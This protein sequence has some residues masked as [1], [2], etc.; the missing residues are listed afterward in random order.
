MTAINLAARNP[1]QTWSS[2]ALLGA[3][4]GALGGAVCMGFGLA[5]VVTG[6]LFGAVYGALFGWLGAAR[7][8]KGGIRRL[9]GAPELTVTGWPW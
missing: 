2:P 9:A 3:A 4:V 5:N 7:R 8:T 1:A 6:V